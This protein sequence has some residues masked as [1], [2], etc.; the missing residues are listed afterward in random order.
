[1]LSVRK[2]DPVEPC[3]V[4]FVAGATRAMFL[5]PYLHTENVLRTVFVIV[6]V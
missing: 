5:G 4:P 1:M 2:S 3:G 6:Q